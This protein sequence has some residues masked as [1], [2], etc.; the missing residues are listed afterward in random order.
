MALPP[1]EPDH[2]IAREDMAKYLD[3]VTNFD[4]QVGLIL[5]QLEADG[6]LESTIV[7]IFGDNGECHVRGKQFCY[8]EGL[9]VPL[10]HGLAEGLPGAGATTRRAPSMSGCSCP[11]T[12]RRRCSTSPARSR[13]R[14]CRARSSGRAGA[15]K[16]RQYVFGARDRC[17]MTVMRIRAVA[18]RRY[19]YI[20]NFTP[21]TPFLAYNAYKE[22]QYPRVDPAAEAAQG[23]QAERRSRP[24]CASRACRDEELYDLQEDPHQVRNLAKGAAHQETLRR[25]S[26]VLNDWIEQTNDQ[27]RIMETPEV[28]ERESKGV[29]KKKK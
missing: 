7:V 10:R 4:R 11:S 6:L 16:D 9:R 12:W 29:A 28:V 25:L 1:Y 18:D 5:A 14:R 22:K 20:R 23:G 24:S 15:A 27:G 13:R 19:R 2:P 3:E 17:D 8:E 21:E 26:G